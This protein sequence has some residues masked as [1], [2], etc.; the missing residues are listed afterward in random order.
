[1]GGVRRGLLLELGDAVYR[2]DD[3]AA[4]S[5]RGRIGELDRLAAQKREEMQA[6]MEATHRRV[7]RGRLE[8]QRT[9]V[10][11][12][13]Q[14]PATPAPGEANPPEPARIPEPYPPP[15]EGTPPQPAVIPE[16]EPAVIPEPGPRSADQ[17]AS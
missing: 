11:E 15:D 6:I 10:A 8:V 9:E 17:E 12:V 4:E 13:P 7:E 16:Q 2:G 1:L 14:E 5:A 3:Q